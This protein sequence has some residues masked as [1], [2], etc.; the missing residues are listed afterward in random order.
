VLKPFVISPTKKSAQE[1]AFIFKI[2]ILDN[3][4]HHLILKNP[5]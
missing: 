1:V 5:S 4:Q 2:Q 3:I